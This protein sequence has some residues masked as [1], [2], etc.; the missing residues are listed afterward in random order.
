MD[1]K[2]SENLN[3]MIAKL[4][5]ESIKSEKMKNE[6][7]A[8]EKEISELREK[9][10]LIE[11]NIEYYNSQKQ[12]IIN[13]KSWRFMGPARILMKYL[14]GKR[15][16]TNKQN[17]E[18]KK[19]HELK[20]IK[21]V[22]GADE[23]RKNN[24]ED[25]IVLLKENIT[26]DKDSLIIEYKNKKLDKIQDTFVLYRILG[27]DLYPRHKKGQTRENLE[28][29]LK[30][31]PTLKDCEKRWIVNRI[32]DKSE[33]AFIISL[34]EQ[35]NQPYIVI[36]FEENE[37][38][39]IGFDLSCISSEFLISDEFQ[40]LGPK[41]R[42][43]LLAALYRH[44]NNYVM[45][46]NG[47]RN[48]AL[49]DGKK[50]AK[51]IL[52]WDGNCF[53]TE[54]AWNS[55]V[56]DI[57]SAPYYKYFAVPMTRVTNNQELLSG[58]FVP[59]PVEEP[60]LIFRMD[61]LEEFNEEF[62]YGRRP[63]VELFWR[64]GISGKWD[65]W[66][67]DPWDLKR[68]ELSAEAGQYGVAGWV[69]R[70]NSGMSELEQ[71]N[72]ESFK[73]R[74][75]ARRDAIL[76]TLQNLDMK[77]SNVT[78]NTFT[79]MNRRS[80][81]EEVAQFKFVKNP[82]ITSLINKLIKDAE[83]ALKRGPYSV[84][85][86]TTLPPSGN[87]HDYWHPA[88]YWWPNP[89][90]KDGLPY[91]KKD[92]ERVPGTQMYHPESEKYDR[93]RL[94]RL[95]DD[96]FILALAWKFTGDTRYARHCV[97]LLETFFVNE[98]TKMNPHLNYAQVRLGHNNNIGFSSGIIEMKDLYYYLDAVRLIQE[99]GLLSED[100]LAK[101]KSWLDEYL[102][103]LLKSPQGRKECKA[104]NNHG[105]YYDLQ[106]AAIAA[107]LNK[108]K[109][110]YSTLI[111][112]L[113]RIKTHFDEDGAQP[114]ELNRTNSQHYCFYNLQGWIN[115]ATLAS[116]WGVDFWSVPEFQKGI[117][118]LLSHQDKKWPYQQNDEFDF[119]RFDPIRIAK[120]YVGKNSAYTHEQVYNMKPI[121]FPHD[122]IRPYWNIGMDSKKYL[123]GHVVV[124]RFGI[125]IFDERWLDHRLKL[126]K[127]ITLP[128]LISQCKDSEF[129]FGL[130]VDKNIPEYYY[131]HLRRLISVIPNAEIRKLELHYD[132][133]V[134][135]QEQIE[136]IVNEK[137]YDYIISTRIDDDDALT[138]GSFSAIMNTARTLVDKGFVPS[139]IIIRHGLRFAPL[140]N[141]GLWHDHDSH[142]TGASVLIPV[143]SKTNIY[144]FNHTKIPSYFKDKGWNVCYIEKDQ[145]A[146]LYTVH[147]YSD[148]DYE[149]KVNKIKNHKDAVVPNQ[150]DLQKFSVNEESLKEWIELERS[151]K[152]LVG[153]KMTDFIRDIEDKIVKL[154]KMLL[155][156]NDNKDVKDEIERLFKERFE[157]GK[158]IVDALEK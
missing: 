23:K 111:R 2:K 73:N 10:R 51:W 142:S 21:I 82:K 40:K 22:E 139:A 63:K 129:Y 18:N 74:G 39:K 144:S 11:K 54:E 109:L 44:K 153:G 4:H 27:N 56:N 1:I 45:N 69:A 68:R 104:K 7:E 86:K 106:V 96:S 95:F 76:A 101:F 156:E 128:S 126:F 33:E 122:G 108:P 42:D 31:E 94:Q 75:L 52:P 145:A 13:S 57:K 66:K 123:I 83:E 135:H 146:W 34:L 29:I 48:T 38:K 72:E 114:E 35:Y 17:E 15:V 37:Y 32:I 117:N 30:Y 80:L 26:K 119:D 143:G 81:E 154:R 84:V 118:W 8:I 124:M 97:Q 98:D 150:E 85:H 100:V 158:R 12:L 91:I 60:Q 131:D 50:R 59:N 140:E 70:M 20:T 152:P 16:T 137:H 127:A 62:C 102:N 25:V 36:P 105:T 79:S 113:S 133:K 155:T 141:R 157:A 61:A 24:F 6:I 77:V 110:L 49:R 87:K 147:K 64:L 3:E 103:W 43:R 41:Q 5:S 55:I 78:S 93:T 58:R 136:R 89:N 112:A 14:K 90:S 99:S 46:N 151:V 107:F 134:D 116:R 132:R 53:I 88:P 115:L 47:A 67:D 148:T 71:N 125:G 121:F 19:I 9:M 120:E 130:Q 28:F 138:T 65:E 92:G 149:S